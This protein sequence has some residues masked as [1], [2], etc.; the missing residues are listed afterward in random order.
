MN[1]NY[2]NE[3]WNLYKK[4]PCGGGQEQ[5]FLKSD[6]NV[7]NV[8]KYDLTSIIGLW[9]EEQSPY[10]KH[11]LYSC[12]IQYVYLPLILDVSTHEQLWAGCGDGQMEDLFCGGRYRCFICSGGIKQQKTVK[13]G[14]KWR[15][16]R[17]AQI[18]VEKLVLAA[19]YVKM[20]LRKVQRGQNA[21]AKNMRIQSA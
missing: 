2:S 11:I 8:M 5:L 17:R 14:R 3:W 4:V 18:R 20:P 16:L 6:E 13:R 15:R 7:L 9:G 12:V 10:L 19:T 1:T 21:T